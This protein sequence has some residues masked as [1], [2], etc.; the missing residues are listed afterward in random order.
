M[1]TFKVKPKFR[2]EKLGELLLK[3]ALW[4]VQKNRYDLIYVATQPSQTYLIQILEYFG[5]QHTLTL[6]RSER[7]YEK[8]IS[9]DRLHLQ[10]GSDVF[11]LDR[12]SYPRFV[13]DS[14]V[15]AYCVPIRGLYHRKLFPEIATQVPLPLFP[16]QQMYLDGNSNRTPGNTIRKVYL[17]RA[18]VSH[19]K[20]GDLLFFYESK[21]PEF[22]AS[23]S[24]TSVGVV[25]AT[26]STADIDELIRL[27]AKRSVFA[28]QELKD[29]VS[30]S[31]VPV[32]VIDFLLVGH[33]EPHIPLNELISM[34][35]FKRHPPQS[36]TKLSWA[37]VAVLKSRLSL[38]FAV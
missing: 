3:Q 10:S 1:C 34:K 25:E 5:F 11:E 15:D 7:V 28:E 27:T 26:N 2:G 35:V 19:M 36:I 14:K 29:I 9:A 31:D 12:L 32:K 18:K 24:I 23:Q 20:S 4:F 22:V 21:T 33:F 30:E 6:N 37:S 38:G 16:N 13:A 17:C 8:I